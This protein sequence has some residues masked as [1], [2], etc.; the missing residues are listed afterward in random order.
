MTY[1]VL[2]FAIAAVFIIAERRLPGRALPHVPGWYL[3]VICLNVCQLAIVILA[4]YTWNRWLLGFSVVSIG[5][6]MPS[7]VEGFLGWFF[8]TFVFYWWHRI[9]HLSTWCWRIF[10]QIHHSPSRIETL[11][12]FYKHPI[13][14]A[15]NSIL[16]ALILYMVLGASLEAAAWYNIFAAAGEMF[17]HSNLKTAHW[18]G[19]FMQRPEHHAIHHQLGVHDFNYGD[20]TWWDRLF[21]TFRDTNQFVPAC[22]FPNQNERHLAAMLLW[23]DVYDV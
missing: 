19:Y 9:R 20:I 21:G 2:I 12:S 1:I 6:T 3:R 13:E 16:T 14:I 15:A 11:T 10:H 17:Y 22:G 8:G 7:S 18:L 5:G 23:Q 4:G